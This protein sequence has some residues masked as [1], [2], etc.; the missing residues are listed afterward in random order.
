MESPYNC[1]APAGLFYGERPVRR[2]TLVDDD[3]LARRP[4]RAAGNKPKSIHDTRQNKAGA[5]G[6]GAPQAHWPPLFSESDIFLHAGH[7]TQTGLK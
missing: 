3:G 6:S 4:S 5:S 1:P 7:R 2:R